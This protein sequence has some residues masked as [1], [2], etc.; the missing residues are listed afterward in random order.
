MVCYVLR[1]PIH[2]EELLSSFIYFTSIRTTYPDPPAESHP[3]RN[4]PVS[5][6]KIKKTH[7]FPPFSYN[8]GY[9]LLTFKPYD[10]DVQALTH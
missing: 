3:P 5:V 4:R 2:N 9:E 6:I 1:Y 10:Y 7:L 8:Q